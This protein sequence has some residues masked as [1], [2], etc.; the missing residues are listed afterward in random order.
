[1]AIEFPIHHSPRLTSFRMLVRLTRKL[2]NCLDGIDVSAY[3]NGDVVDVTRQE[4]ELLIA[5]GWASPVGAGLIDGVPAPS[6]LMGG[7]RRAPSPLSA[8]VRA[9]ANR[10]AEVW[11]RPGRR[12]VDERDLRRVE[13]I[14]RDELRD[15]RAKTIRP[16]KD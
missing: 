12:R 11:E 5:E 2:A 4:A 7:L 16:E 1:M 8:S 10:L 9:E 3:Q 6:S 15:A 14:I 13:D